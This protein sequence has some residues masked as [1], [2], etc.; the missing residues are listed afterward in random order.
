MCSMFESGL[1]SILILERMQIVRTTA[2]VSRKPRR[3]VIS[4]DDDDDDVVPA[5]AA[6]PVV[7]VKSAAPP[8]PVASPPPSVVAT[9][10]VKP[11]TARP[12][13]PKANSSAELDPKSSS[14]P[15]SKSA[16]AKPVGKEVPSS[17]GKDAKDGP[18]GSTPLPPGS[19]WVSFSPVPTMIPGTDGGWGGARSRRKKS[20]NVERQCCQGHGHQRGQQGTSLVFVSARTSVDVYP[21][22]R[23]SL[24]VPHACLCFPEYHGASPAIARCV[25]AR[26]TS[27]V[28]SPLHSRFVSI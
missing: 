3:G 23:P 12:A 4:D 2:G 5:A 16:A 14:L 24:F 13:E 21:L 20:G 10:A 1:V 8:A 19:S 17:A 26:F 22:L 18:L 9:A 7:A 6:V 27:G 15:T 25:R 28:R 11:A